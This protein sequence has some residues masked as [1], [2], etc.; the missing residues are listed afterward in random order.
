[1]FAIYITGTVIAMLIVVVSAVVYIS[2]SIEKSLT[3]FSAKVFEESNRNVVHMLAEQ[4]K[5]NYI[6]LEMSDQLNKINSRNPMDC[7]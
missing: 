6:L 2:Q 3:T 1:M 4:K 7:K 5:Q